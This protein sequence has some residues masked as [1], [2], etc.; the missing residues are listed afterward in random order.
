MTPMLAM[1]LPR[2]YFMEDCLWIDLIAIGCM[3]LG[4][5]A[6]ARH[7]FF[8]LPC[9]LLALGTFAGFS[10]E[11]LFFAHIWINGYQ[12]PPQLYAISMAMSSVATLGFISLALGFVFLAKRERKLSPELARP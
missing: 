1:N 6:A 8:R 12:I 11:P 4:S 3:V 5:T 9:L 10:P 7:P 2:E